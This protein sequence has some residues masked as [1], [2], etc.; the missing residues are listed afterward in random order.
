MRS[1]RTASVASQGESQSDAEKQGRAHACR[2]C[3]TGDGSCRAAVLPC[4]PSPMESERVSKGFSAAIDDKYFLGQRAPSTSAN[5]RGHRS[6]PR[7]QASDVEADA[8]V[9][10]YAEPLTQWLL[11][12]RLPLCA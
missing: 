7:R 1:Q 12:R 5:S 6:L 8:A 10:E 2:G 11:N 9:E 4:E 3:S